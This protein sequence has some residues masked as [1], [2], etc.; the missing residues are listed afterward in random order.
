MRHLDLSSALADGT[1]G[2]RTAPAIGPDRNRLRHL[3]LENLV[4]K[5]GRLAARPLDPI[6]EATQA[7]VDA[8]C[9]MYITL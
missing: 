6:G 8:A 5:M 9:T 1:L 7:A 2:R 4:M 3:T